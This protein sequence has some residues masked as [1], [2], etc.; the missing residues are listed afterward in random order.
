VPCRPELGQPANQGTAGRRHRALRSGDD[1]N[2][3]DLAFA[4]A[5]C[6]GG[7]GGRAPNPREREL[8]E[9]WAKHQLNQPDF[10]GGQLV[11]FLKQV[12]CS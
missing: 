1:K 11:A 4:T 10:S 3:L 12:G 8:F 5:A 2:E 7:G 9:L 6:G